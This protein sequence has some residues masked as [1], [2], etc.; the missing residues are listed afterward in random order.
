[1]KAFQNEPKVMRHM[2][3]AA[4]DVVAREPELQV[5]RRLKADLL[6]EDVRPG[7]KLMAG[8]RA[9]EVVGL[10]RAQETSTGAGM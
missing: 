7:G 3:L 2:S 8:E 1:M 5:L 6:P 10:E 4:E 9:E